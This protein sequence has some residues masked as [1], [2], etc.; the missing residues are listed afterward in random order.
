MPSKRHGYLTRKEWLR[1]RLEDA[2]DRTGAFDIERLLRATRF[3]YNEFDY[4]AQ[5]LIRKD[6]E[7]NQTFPPHWTEN[8][9]RQ[10][11]LDGFVVE[12]GEASATNRVFRKAPPI[13]VYV[14]MPNIEI[15]IE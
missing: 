15:D 11:L 4:R 6:G 14:A 12:V 10:Y 5:V 7:T 13:S 1:Q 9:R 2:R 8:Q 3:Y